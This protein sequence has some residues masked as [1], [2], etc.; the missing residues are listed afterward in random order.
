M[1]S[2]LPLVPYIPAADVPRAR[3]FY[4]EKLGA[5][6]TNVSPAGVLY[7]C[8]GATFFMYTSAGAGTSKA[9][10]AFW[11]VTNIEEEMASLRAK[12]VAFEHY[13]LPGLEWKDEV[14]S[15]GG[16]KNAWFKDSEGNIL[17]LIQ[18]P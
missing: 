18:A 5:R 17:A 13:D 1:I 2:K 15:V 11:S 14:A 9:S 12:G 7:D 4:E 3:K 16:F 8:G 6:P 10:L